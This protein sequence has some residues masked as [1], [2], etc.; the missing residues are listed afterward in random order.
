VAAPF[1]LLIVLGVLVVEPHGRTVGTCQLEANRVAAANPWGRGEALRL[2]VHPPL[3]LIQ[4]VP[5][6]EVSA[7]IGANDAV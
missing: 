5:I 3:L 2:R 1:G 4:I 6:Y 7:S